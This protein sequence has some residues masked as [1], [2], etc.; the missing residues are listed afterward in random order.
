MVVLHATSVKFFKAAFNLAAS[1]KY[2]KLKSGQSVRDVSQPLASAAQ[3]NNNN[4]KKRALPA[5]T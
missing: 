5:R 2:D 4:K 3:K 1:L